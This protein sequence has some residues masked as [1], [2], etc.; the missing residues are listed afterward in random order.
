M[1]HVR[2]AFD[3]FRRVQQAPAAVPA[4][5]RRAVEPA[6]NVQPRIAVIG[7]KPDLHKLPGCVPLRHNPRRGFELRPSAR[8]RHLPRLIDAARRNQFARVLAQEALVVIEG[9]V[10]RVGRNAVQPAVVHR[11]LPARLKEL[12]LPK[13][14][15]VIRRF[16]QVALIEVLQAQERPARGPFAH[17]KAVEPHDIRRVAPRHGAQQPL[18]VVRLV[19]RGRLTHHHVNPRP[20]AGPVVAR[21]E[22]PQHLR[23]K[24]VEF[25][26]PKIQRDGFGG[27]LRDGGTAQPCGRAQRQRGQPWQAMP[28][29]RCPP[30]RPE[31]PVC[32]KKASAHPAPPC[33]SSNSR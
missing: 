33:C 4:H 21:L 19:H 2:Q 31:S 9:P 7:D 15:R 24:D 6:V 27:I 32:S 1:G 18:R 22:V 30:R 3:D 20:A 11:L 13:R 5:V 28:R 10:V 17:G 14:I 12:L 16:N 25:I 8:R 23:D 26:A 29:R